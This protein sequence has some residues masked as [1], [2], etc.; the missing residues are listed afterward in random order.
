[1]T[2]PQAGDVLVFSGPWA[3][4]ISR[5]IR[6]GTCSRWTHCAGVVRLKGGDIRRAQKRRVERGRPLLAVSPLQWTDGD[7]LFESTTLCGLPCL[8]QDRLVAGVQVHGIRERV[9]AYRGSVWVRRLRQPL[10]AA[11]HRLL[12]D[13]VLD[14]VGTPYDYTGAAVSATWLWKYWLGRRKAADTRQLYCS[15]VML[16]A[17]QFAL[18]RRIIRRV[19]SGSLPPRDVARWQNRLYQ[20]LELVREA[21]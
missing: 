16:D 18:H 9:D 11:E 17:Y 19:T 1:M 14:A 8:V 7:Y 3:D 20:P 15:E 21:A 10:Y 2:P 13:W 5:W 6:L 4:R 12:A